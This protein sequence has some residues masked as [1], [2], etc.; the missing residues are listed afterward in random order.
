MQSNPKVVARGMF[1]SDNVIGQ[2]GQQN[3]CENSH[4]LDNRVKFPAPLPTSRPWHHT[5]CTPE[6]SNKCADM[7]PRVSAG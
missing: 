4:F 5:E 6:E 1:R 2:Q 7:L 3:Y